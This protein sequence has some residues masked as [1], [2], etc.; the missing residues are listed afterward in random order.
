[1]NIK[2]T[3]A[4]VVALSVATTAPFAAPPKPNARGG[5]RPLT[6]TNTV[7]FFR[8]ALGRAPLKVDGYCK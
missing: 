7:A 4:L 5:S 2:Q 6:F 8:E 3:I 1:M